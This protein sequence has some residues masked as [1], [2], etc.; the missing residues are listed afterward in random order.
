M[1]ESSLFVDLDTVDLDLKIHI[2]KRILC[3]NFSSTFGV[4][5]F[6]DEPIWF[7]KHFLL[8][9]NKDFIK[10]QFTAT[11][12]EAINMILSEEYFTKVIIG[13]TFMYGIIEFYAK[14]KLGFRPDEFDFF[15]D[16]NLNQYRKMF[17]GNAIN[18]LKKT[19]ASIAKSLNEIDKHNLAYL[20]ECGIP[21]ER[22]IKGKIADRLTLGRNPMLHGERY[23]FFSEGLYLVMLYILFHL[24]DSKDEITKK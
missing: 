18:K 12:K 19:N 4:I 17:I 3:H 13:T 22:W 11:I 20:K 10:P 23:I 8:S 16:K 2:A 1:K 24:Y 9:Y 21:E 15:D 7:I 14:Y 5:Y 6:P